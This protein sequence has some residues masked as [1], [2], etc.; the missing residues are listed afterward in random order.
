M[1]ENGIEQSLHTAILVESAEREFEFMKDWK[2]RTDAITYSIMVK[3]Y[4]REDKVPKDVEI[5][6]EM[7]V[8]NVEP[9][10]ITYLT[11]IYACYTGLCKEGKCMEG[12]AVFQKMISRWCK[13]NIAILLIWLMHMQSLLT[14]GHKISR[15]R[16]MGLTLMKWLKGLSLMDL[17][18]ATDWRRPRSPSIHVKRVI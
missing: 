18:G 3:E 5:L 11:F 12:Y 2:I 6:M 14:R 10:R 15:E 16:E 8:W 7:A 1:K 13:Q 9:N 4:R 17:A